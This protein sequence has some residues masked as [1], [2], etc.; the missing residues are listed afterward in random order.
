M[1]VRKE[2]EESVAKGLFLLAQKCANIDGLECADCLFYQ[3]EDGNYSCELK[4]TVGLYGYELMDVYEN[5]IILPT[6][7]V[8]RKEFEE[9]LQ[10][11]G[12]M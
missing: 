2:C 9:K 6:G 1:N 7:P 11:R 5:Y 10:G 4:N 8:D 12:H 3:P